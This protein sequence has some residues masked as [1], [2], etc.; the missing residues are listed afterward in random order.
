MDSPNQ[1]AASSAQGAVPLSCQLCRKRKIRCDKQNPCGNCV[2]AQKECVPVVRAR[3]PRGRNGGRKAMNAELRSRINRLEG[4]VQSLNA[5]LLPDGASIDTSAPKGRT[6][7]EPRISNLS[8]PHLLP[9]SHQVG[10]REA[11]GDTT[12]WL[13]STL[14]SQLAHELT[15]LHSVLEAEDEDDDHENMDASSPS[16]TTDSTGTPKDAIIFNPQPTPPLH[17]APNLS[18]NE[19]LEYLKI[20]RRNVDIPLKFVHI[21]SFERLLLAKEP[22]LGQPAESMVCQALVSAAFYACICS[23]SN[24][25]CLSTFGKT[26]QVL[27][28]EWQHTTYQCLAKVEIIRAPSLAS[29]QALMLYIVSIP[30]FIMVG[31]NN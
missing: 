4:L 25:H 3:L 18:D 27:R 26:K 8:D 29:L 15:G 14:W 24:S 19:V 17:S 13:G 2:T 31:K 28:D 6:N 10:S 9:E 12:R 11:T 5:G 23:I 30:I 16:V 1:P 20:F 7:S 21:P 22:Y